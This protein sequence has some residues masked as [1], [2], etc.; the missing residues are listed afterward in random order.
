MSQ[1]VK[2]VC[3]VLLSLG[4]GFAALETFL[5]ITLRYPIVHKVVPDFVTKIS[6]RIYFAYDMK[7]IQF[8]PESSRYDRELAYTLRPGKFIFSNAEFATEYTV[9][10]LG[11]RDTEASLD[12]P[13]IIVLGDS[14]A[15]GWGVG[16]NQTF[17]KLLEA[18]TGLR[19]LN[20]AV[21]SYGTAREMILLRKIKK[22]KFKYLIIQYCENDYEENLSFKKN[23]NK[24]KIMS[25]D[26]YERLVQ[27]DREHLRYYFGK[28]F[29]GA[30]HMIKRD[31]LYLFNLVDRK[32]FIAELNRG[33]QDEAAI[34]IYVL[35]NSGIDLGGKQLIVFSA[36]ENTT[37]TSGLKEQIADSNYPSYIRNMIIIDT[38]NII[39]DNERLLLD[40]HYNASGHQ[41]LA[42]KLLPYIKY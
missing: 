25:K 17:A 24:L 31:Y 27:A 23:G 1:T 10:S 16:Q 5:F 29:S 9:N 8:L 13:R 36:T 42:D 40:G 21:A 20:A 38:T 41:A 15:M 35:V 37:F 7:S 2:N 14:Y 18:K 32:K 11:V 26:E 22:D 4:L 39:T 19:V 12:S 28:F 30:I 6:R 34:F 3:L 33:P